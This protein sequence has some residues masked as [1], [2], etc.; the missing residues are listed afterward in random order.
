MALLELLMVAEPLPAAKVALMEL[1]KES[2][3]LT[4]ADDETNK[5]PVFKG[6]DVNIP[7]PVGVL[8]GVTQEL[9]ELLTLE[10]TVAVVDSELLT[11]LHAETLAQLDAELESRRDLERKGE[12]VALKEAIEGEG[13]PELCRLG[14]E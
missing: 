4:A 11:L 1:L 8:L 13:E 10:L 5:L 14:V 7:L 6:V 3:P 9:I 2:E 12:A